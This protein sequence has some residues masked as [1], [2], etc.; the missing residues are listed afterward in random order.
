MRQQKVDASR[1]DLLR[2]RR[3]ERGAM[4]THVGGKTGEAWGRYVGDGFDRGGFLR[5]LRCFLALRS[6]MRI[7][8]NRGAGLDGLLDDVVVGFE[9]VK[10]S[11]RPLREPK[12]GAM[13][14]ENQTKSVGRHAVSSQ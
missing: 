2:A 1:L 14:I 13:R 8:V 6:Q 11:H 3:Q 7:A 4:R 9:R 10:H 5:V 12:I